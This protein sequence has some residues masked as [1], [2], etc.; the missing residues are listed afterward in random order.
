MC[1][2]MKKQ[3]KLQKFNVATLTKL[4]SITGGTMTICGTLAGA[5]DI[6][7]PEKTKPKTKCRSIEC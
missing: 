6:H 7:C 2:K 3:L 5:T 1:K 4:E